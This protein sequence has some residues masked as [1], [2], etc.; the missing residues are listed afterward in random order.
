ML[1][2]SFRYIHPALNSLPYGQTELCCLHPSSSYPK[3]PP[4]SFQSG[5]L[6]GGGQQSEHRNARFIMCWLKAFS[7]RM[8][9]R[10]PAKPERALPPSVC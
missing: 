4:E 7:F 5:V 2:P 3:V 6:E 9:G 1:P 8:G 10:G